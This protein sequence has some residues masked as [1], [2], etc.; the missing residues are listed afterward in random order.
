MIECHCGRKRI[1]AHLTESNIC[2]QAL[3]SPQCSNTDCR[4]VL[5]I[6]GCR[7][8]IRGYQQPQEKRNN[9]HDIR[10][11]QA[12]AHKMRT[13]KRVR[14]QTNDKAEAYFC[15]HQAWVKDESMQKACRKLMLDRV[16]MP[17]RAKAV[18]LRLFLTANHLTSKQSKQASN[19]IREISGYLFAQNRSPTRTT[20][21]SRATR[22]RNIVL[23]R[24]SKG[25][26]QITDFCTC[27]IFSLLF[28]LN[29][30]PHSTI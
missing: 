30:V 14:K 11:E 29:Y 24:W 10:S 5:Q 16:F 19:L 13:K 3:L 21:G 15:N 1:T 20:S 18:I 23:R 27:L 2:R 26:L 8:F 9:E 22:L 28:K 7:R 12:L 4:R 25:V 6:L 17:D